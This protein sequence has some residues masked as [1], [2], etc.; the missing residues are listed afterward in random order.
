MELNHHDINDVEKKVKVVTDE[1]SP[2]IAEFKQKLADT[3]ESCETAG[4]NNRL[5]ILCQNS[6]FQEMCT[7]ELIIA[8]DLEVSEA[9]SLGSAQ[10]MGFSLCRL[11][12]FKQ[13]LLN[14]RAA[15]STGNSE[16][17]KGI[18]R[19]ILNSVLTPLDTLF[20]QIKPEPEVHKSAEILTEDKEE[21]TPETPLDGLMKEDSEDEED[22]AVNNTHFGYEQG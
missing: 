5:A 19:I 1:D 21:F 22:T 14:L 10:E 18:E 4:N 12:T 3:L 15:Y 8:L 6:N 20:K 2:E 13:K 16:S 7:E 9:S 11:N 17:K